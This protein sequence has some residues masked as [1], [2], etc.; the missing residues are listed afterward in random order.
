[1]SDP[2]NLSADAEPLFEHIKTWDS[3][4]NMIDGATAMA[5][6]ISKPMLSRLGTIP[7]D[8][9]QKRLERFNA[10]EF[11]ENQ[12]L[13]VTVEYTAALLLLMADYLPDSTDLQRQL[14]Q[15]LHA[16]A[17][18]TKTLNDKASAGGLSYLSVPKNLKQI[19]KTMDAF[20]ASCTAFI[21]CSTKKT[22]PQAM[23]FLHALK[24][25]LNS[26]AI[27]KLSGIFSVFNGVIDERKKVIAQLKLQLN[28]AL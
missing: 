19:I 5:T 4:D 6:A 14:K 22:T 26:L 16:L 9:L 1:M 12:N 28:E 7:Y 25:F 11:I 8:A 21:Q 18:H 17:T 3:D 13:V 24:H 10:L 27:P 23:V 20:F 2:I 15:Q